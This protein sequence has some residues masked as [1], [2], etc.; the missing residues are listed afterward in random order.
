MEYAS[1]NPWSVGYVFHNNPERV[2]REF[3]GGDNP[4][5][6]RLGHS[7][8]LPS[9][10]GSCQLSSNVSPPSCPQIPLVLRGEILASPREACRWMLRLSAFP[11]TLSGIPIQ[12]RDEGGEAA[13]N[14]P[15]KKALG[16]VLGGR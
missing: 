1:D 4:F 12:K 16:V 2:F 3:F 6:G 15:G 13:I 7:G 8:A 5:A 14:T 10:H 11:R 9:F